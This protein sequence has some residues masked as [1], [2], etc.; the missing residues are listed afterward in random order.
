M[1]SDVIAA[2]PDA[3]AG[4]SIGRWSRCVRCEALR[5]PP[6]AVTALAL[7][8]AHSKA[9]GARTSARSWSAAMESDVIAAFLART[10]TGASVDARVASAAQSGDSA[11]APSR[12]LQDASA[13]ARGARISARSWSAAMSPT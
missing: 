5:P 1:E 8:H 2:F 13:T 4:W 3:C 10:R 9:R 12:A 11:N 7:R 6:K